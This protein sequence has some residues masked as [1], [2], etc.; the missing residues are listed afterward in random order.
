[1]QVITPQRGEEEFSLLGRCN[2]HYKCRVDGDG[3]PI[4]LLVGYAGKYKVGEGSDAKELPFVGLEYANYAAIERHGPANAL[5]AQRIIG[6]L[7]F[8]L[9]G[10]NLPV[11][12][13]E[14]TDVTGFIGAPEG[15][16]ALAVAMATLTGRQYIFPDKE[17][18]EAKS[19]TSREKSKLV[20]GR[21]MP[22][23]GEEWILSEDTTNNFATT[24]KM[25]SLIES[26]G[27]KVVA[28]TCFLNRTVLP[29]FNEFF[30]LAE[31]RRV[32]II[33]LVRRPIP[34]YRQDDPVVAELVKA[35]RVI[36]KPK[37]NWAELMV[38][39]G[40]YGKGK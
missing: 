25:I 30:T 39:M 4:G 27:A 37:D 38:S 35:N 31:G 1:M 18:I 24:A 11:N 5:I 19:A 2:G 17:V 14:G 3:K 13:L 10:R 12:S 21:H 29:E 40:T 7:G 34:E 33:A 26:C 20:W 9:T 16:K 15:G 28:I 22:E 36:W 6:R 32:P 23:A 8:G